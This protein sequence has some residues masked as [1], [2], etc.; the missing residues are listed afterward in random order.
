MESTALAFGSLFL[1]LVV[2]RQPVELLVAPPVASVELRLDGRAVGTLRQQPWRVDI[3]LGSD[4]LPHHLVAVG[5]DEKGREVAR[6]LQ[7][8]NLPR[9]P[10]ELEVALLRDAG[11]RI[12]GARLSF[13]A[14]VWK[15]PSRVRAEL[16]GAELAVD[17]D[18]AAH[19]PPLEARGTHLL[20]AS[21]DYGDGVVAV[22]EVVFGRDV[23]A[24]AQ[25]VLSGVALQYARPWEAPSLEK[26]RGRVRAQGRPVPVVAVEQGRVRLVLVIDP[27]VHEELHRIANDALSWGGSGGESAVRGTDTIIRVDPRPT[28]Q[29]RSDGLRNAVFP[30]RVADEVR[31]DELPRIL[32]AWLPRT[33]QDV[34]S[35]LV[36]AVAVG[37]LMAAA[38][39]QRRAVVLITADAARS[40]DP[41]PIARVRAFLTALGVPLVVWTPR[42]EAAGTP[43]GPWGPISDVSRYVD[44][45]DADARLEKLLR[46]QRLCWVEGDWLPPELSLDG[47][48]HGVAIA[49]RE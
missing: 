17:A 15:P 24:E 22:R 14:A 40:A 29:A 21:V 23:A 49:G 6:C 18:G 3:D 8:I 25:S 26:L 47:A 31:V 1:G 32:F 35:R 19:W 30:V 45:S 20:R 37:G 12:S 48:P 4:L 33:G 7:R 36:D 46:R 38:G 13:Q 11:G 34:G 44:L 43:L 41:A 28:V 27:A 5:R 39:S 9:A 2:G 16:D 10:A 42:A